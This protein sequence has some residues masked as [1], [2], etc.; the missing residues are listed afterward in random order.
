MPQHGCKPLECL[1]ALFGLPRL[2]AWA[3]SQRAVD[4]RQVRRDPQRAKRPPVDEDLGDAIKA[5]EPRTEQDREHA[6]TPPRRFGLMRH[7]TLGA[8]SGRST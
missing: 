6:A 8:A 3:A 5:A 1:P 4:G 7:V 2:A